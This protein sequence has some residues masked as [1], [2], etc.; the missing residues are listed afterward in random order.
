MAIN[1]SRG[2]RQAALGPTAGLGEYYPETPFPFDELTRGLPRSTGSGGKKATPSSTEKP[3][4]LRAV[5]AF[6]ETIEIPDDDLL[7]E[8][9]ANL[10]QE[11]Q[12]TTDALV[13]NPRD[14]RNEKLITDYRS[15]K[16]AAELQAE[17]IKRNKGQIDN[18]RKLQEGGKHN[19]HDLIEAERAIRDYAIART[20]DPE[21]V[22]DLNIEDMIAQ[23]PEKMDRG[24]DINTRLTSM[25]KR[26]GAFTKQELL[27]AENMSVQEVDGEMVLVGVTA[28]GVSSNRVAT[29]LDDMFKSQAF[30]DDVNREVEAE[31]ESTGIQ[32]EGQLIPGGTS[33]ATGTTEEVRALKQDILERHKAAAIAK[34]SG[35]NYKQTASRVPDSGGGRGRYKNASIGDASKEKTEL[36]PIVKSGGAFMGMLD[37]EGKEFQKIPIESNTNKKMFMVDRNYPD[38]GRTEGTPSA[39][40]RI[41]GVNYILARSK[42]LY[43]TEKMKALD[44]EKY[45]GADVGD[46]VTFPVENDVLIRYDANS[47]AFQNWLGPNGEDFG[48]P[49][50]GVEDAPPTK[51]LSDIFGN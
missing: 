51:D 30:N 3:Q 17:K 23:L 28:D 26:E 12:A 37:F 6:G 27:D 43:L 15:K 22:P 29:V 42:E 18:F 20:T 4:G 39:F 48:G 2:Q 5:A 49:D 46:R 14:P 19:S 33:L 10:E 7:N 11:R 25:I 21:N 40:Y 41:D 50:F 16:Q 38:A 36:V 32:G 13:A 8:M 31:F 44:S 47:S 1:F 34:F 24:K 9:R 35:A 45:E